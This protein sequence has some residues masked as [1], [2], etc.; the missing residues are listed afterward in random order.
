M[1]WV[2][3]GYNSNWN[4]SKNINVVENKIHTCAYIYMNILFL[5][6]V[7]IFL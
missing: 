3:L 1:L 6:K 4:N 2:S 5:L 7:G